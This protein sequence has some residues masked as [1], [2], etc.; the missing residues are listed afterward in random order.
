MMTSPLNG[1]VF[2]TCHSLGLWG[3]DSNRT[4]NRRQIART[5]VQRPQ[6]H[7]PASTRR[8]KVSDFFIGWNLSTLRFVYH[9]KTAEASS[10]KVL[11]YSINLMHI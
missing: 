6:C 8:N 10:S 9:S 3:T 2:V 4:G 11:L 5:K 7:G 1:C